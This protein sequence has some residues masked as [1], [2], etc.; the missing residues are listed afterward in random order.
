MLR[1]LIEVFTIGCL[2]SSTLGPQPWRYCKTKY[3]A[4]IYFWGSYHLKTLNYVYFCSCFNHKWCRK[5]KVN[6]I[7]LKVQSALSLYIYINSLWQKSVLNE[8]PFAKFSFLN[9]YNYICVRNSRQ[10]IVK[11]IVIEKTCQSCEKTSYRKTEEF[12]ESSLYIYWF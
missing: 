9:K 5:Q 3:S 8:L 1:N 11:W 4:I 6:K 10:A 12:L 7:N 2:C